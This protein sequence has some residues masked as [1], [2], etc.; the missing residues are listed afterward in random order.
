MNPS[1]VYTLIC[2]GEEGTLELTIDADG[3][4]INSRIDVF[5]ETAPIHGTFN[6]IDGVI[7]FRAK[8][9]EDNPN[10]QFSGV[11]MTLKQT[12]RT[13]FAGTGSN[14]VPAMNGLLPATNKFGWFATLKISNN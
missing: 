9:S 1:G 10:L 3:S 5:G 4:L 8:P 7:E 2:N 14:Y 6:E 13:A 11:A 12:D